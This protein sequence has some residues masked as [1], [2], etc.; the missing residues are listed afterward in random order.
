[1]DEWIDS[2][3]YDKIIILKSMVLS[4]IFL[5]ITTWRYIEEQRITPSPL[6][7]SEKNTPD[8]TRAIERA[9][10]SIH[11]LHGLMIIGSI[12]I[13][14]ISVYG[15][16]NE[17]IKNNDIINAATSDVASGVNSNDGEDNSNI[18]DSTISKFSYLGIDDNNWHIVSTRINNILRQD[19]LIIFGYV[20]FVCYFCKMDSIILCFV[21]FLLY[22][23]CICRFYIGQLMYL[24]LTFGLWNK[25]ERIDMSAVGGN[26]ILKWKHI[27]WVRDIAV[28]SLVFWYQFWNI[29][30]QINSIIF[31][32]IKALVSKI[33]LSKS[34]IIASSNWYMIDL[35]I[36]AGAL[37]IATFISFTSLLN[38]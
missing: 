35:F 22:F 6:H 25:V 32:S 10:V 37:H 29:E 17:S 13:V 31:L 28:V 1:M 33:I 18:I 15:K 8:S 19:S 14:F 26:E 24:I 11:C 20:W 38:A 4:V 12:I 21:I 30:M 7:R 27:I 36:T 2:G 23:C 5:Y 34:S 16:N 3:W 9:Y